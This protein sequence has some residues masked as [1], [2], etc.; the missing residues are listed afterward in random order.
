MCENLG[1]SNLIGKSSCHHIYYEIANDEMGMSINQFLNKCIPEWVLA[2]DRF[3]YKTEL[4]LFEN[5]FYK[6]IALT[7][8]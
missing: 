3:D 4:M 7:N 8:K 1:L 6:N 5:L 2:A